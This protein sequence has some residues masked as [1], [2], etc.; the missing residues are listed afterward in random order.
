MWVRVEG[1]VVGLVK[2]EVQDA[3]CGVRCSR[4]LGLVQ[5]L[6]GRVFMTHL[7]TLQKHV[8]I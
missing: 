2:L 3:G 8:V 1:L 7:N 5:A 4:A 6:K